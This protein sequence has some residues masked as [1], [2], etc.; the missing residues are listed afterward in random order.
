[1]LAAR[2]SKAADIVFDPT[3]FGANVDQVLHTL[4]ILTRL[5]QQIRNQYQ[6]L[7]NWR[8]SRLEELLASM[9]AI[10]ENVAAAVVD[11]AGQYPIDAPAYAGLD[12]E[13]VEALRQ[14]W[15]ESQRA[16]V[17]Q[18]QA[19][20]ARTVSEMPGTQARVSK[21]VERS[22][23]APGQTAVLQASNETLA[24]LTAQM[25]NLQA[26]EIAQTRTELEADAH[27]Q[28]QAAFHRQRRDA[29]MRDWPT[30]PSAQRS[31]LTV[32]TLFNRSGS[33]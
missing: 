13:A 1:M 18:T 27:R 31:S 24:T 2:T 14:R 32:G 17:L 23:A 15:L 3:N 4:E 7:K 30:G 8:F 12:A 16:G 6:M 25:Q 20:H 11:L 29:L 33:R 21:Y 28:A 9:S 10:R 19:L 22:N 26:L 5:D